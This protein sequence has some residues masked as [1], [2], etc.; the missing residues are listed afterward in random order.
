MRKVSLAQL[1]LLLLLFPLGCNTAQNPAPNVDLEVVE[2][3]A[4]KD[5]LAMT[6][7]NNGANA[8]PVFKVELA[9]DSMYLET[10]DKKTITADQLAA[11]QMTTLETINTLTSTDG[12][13]QHYVTARAD[14]DSAIS[15]T[16]E[17]NNFH[18]AFYYDGLY[19]AECDTIYAKYPLWVADLKGWLD[20]WYNFPISYAFN[21]HLLDEVLSGSDSVDGLRV[22]RTINSITTSVILFNL[23]SPHEGYSTYVYDGVTYSVRTSEEVVGHEYTH[24]YHRQDVVDGSSVN[25][26][27]DVP[28]WFREGLANYTSGEG[29]KQVRFQVYYAKHLR[30]DSLAETK[31]NLIDGL[32]GDVRDSVDAAEDY[33]AIKFILVKSNMT[34]LRNILHDNATG[35]SIED[36]IVAHL[37]GIVTSWTDFK[38]QFKTYAEGIIDDT[39]PYIPDH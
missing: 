7:R 38:N 18:S 31:A 20:T 33:L 39:W 19:T 29:P 26:W 32:E 10:Y 34:T 17:D 28:A 11:G 14:Y 13:G 37:S 2:L 8:S 12:V 6:I 9:L 1:F 5:T 30:G 16:N 15:E 25:H 35:S 4:N 24:A 36:A 23:K 22:T 3:T 21:V 27:N